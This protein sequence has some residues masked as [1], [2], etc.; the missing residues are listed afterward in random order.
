MK[1]SVHVPSVFRL[2]FRMHL[3][4]HI[5]YTCFIIASLILYEF[6]VVVKLG[7]GP[8]DREFYG[9]G[10]H[11]L[12]AGIAGSIHAGSMDVCLCLYVLCCPVPVEAFATS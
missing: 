10:L 12:V 3:L 9:V 8:G 5:D 11:P 6:N 1:R 2:R 7:A 4:S